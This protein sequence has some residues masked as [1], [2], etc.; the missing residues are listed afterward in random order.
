MAFLGN[1]IAGIA[2]VIDAALTFYF[3]I[4]IASAIL[5]WV[6]P[7]PYNPIVRF[8]RG[9]TEPA[10]FYVRRY[11]PFVYIGGFDLS[12]IILIFAIQFCKF[13]VVKNLEL[14]A[15]KLIGGKLL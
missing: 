13:A 15:I 9:V 8:L 14:L 2:W 11:I 12:P 6:N 4:I 7:D 3:F 10:Y 1:I 5:S